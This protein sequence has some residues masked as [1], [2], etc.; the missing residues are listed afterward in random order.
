MLRKIPFRIG[1]QFNRVSPLVTNQSVRNLDLQEHHSKELLARHNVRV[2][3]GIV[4]TNGA[5][6]V[7]AAEELRAQGCRDIIVKS[8]I[9]AGGRGKGT[10]NTGFKGM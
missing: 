4:A 3:K 1:A 9:L 6:T 7:K 2:Q 5:E 8:Q 10:F